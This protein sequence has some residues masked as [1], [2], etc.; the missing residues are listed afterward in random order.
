MIGAC[1][2]PDKC[3]LVKERG[4]FAAID[5]K[6]ENLKE[7]VKELTGGKG[8]NIIVDAVGGDIFNQS[9]RW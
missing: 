1:G 2:S 5:Y 4:A 6:T 3:A 7:R 9:L 8:A